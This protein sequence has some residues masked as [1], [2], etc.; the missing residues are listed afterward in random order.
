MQ[1]EEIKAIVE[2]EIDNSIGFIDSETTDQRQKALEYYLRDPYGNE[3][4]GRSQIVTGEVAEAIDG[5]LP[6]LIRVFTTTEDIVLFEPQSAGDEDAAR[7]ATQ[8][9][10]WVFY[11]DNPGFII[12]HNWFKDALLQKV[13]ADQTQ[14]GFKRGIV[15][16]DTCCGVALGDREH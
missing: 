10:N 8:Y 2:A 1:S 11:R 6:Q 5:A 13:G 15:W 12:L 3:Q 7:Q 9:C 14:V 4:E 16:C